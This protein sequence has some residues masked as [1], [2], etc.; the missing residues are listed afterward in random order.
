MK[1]RSLAATGV[2]TALFLTC[3]VAGEAAAGQDRIIENV[4]FYSGVGHA[5]AETAQSL[6]AARVLTV[7]GTF[8]GRWPG[9]QSCQPD[10]S[11]VAFGGYRITRLAGWSLGRLGPIYALGYLR[12]HA[13][14]VARDIDY[15]VMYDPG[16]P[17]DFNGSCDSAPQV[18]ASN[19]L[20]WWL[21]MPGTDHRLVVVAGTLTATDDYES[22]RGTYFPAIR[23]AGL[24][25]RLRVLVCG[26]D[27]DHEQ[28][29]E[30][31][32]RLM[33]GPRLLTVPAALSC[34]A[35]S[36]RPVPGWNP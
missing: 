5:G 10:A 9:Q 31:Y 21:G 11:A 2:A 7:D 16:S 26:Y 24:A 15:I 14:A 29:Y 22:I 4:V 3:G 13:P 36:G 35:Q 33:T 12:S 25:T 27:L 1:I 8:D 6:G 34:P 18:D 17:E 23:A 32:A 30:K 28:A 19:V 20:A